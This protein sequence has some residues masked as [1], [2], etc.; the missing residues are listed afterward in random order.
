MFIGKNLGEPGT[1]T[2]FS[3]Q[4]ET[5]AADDGEF[6]IS[7]EQ[8]VGGRRLNYHCTISVVLHSL[9]FYLTSC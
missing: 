2:E 9:G 1:E 4:G 7:N 5:R 6:G 3:K 8:L